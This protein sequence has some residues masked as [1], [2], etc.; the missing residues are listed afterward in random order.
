[1]DLSAVLLLPSPKHLLS[2]HGKP[3]GNIKIKKNNNNNYNT[4]EKTTTKVSKCMY[5]SKL[6]FCFLYIKYVSQHFHLDKYQFAIHFQ[7]LM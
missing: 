6:I 5:T 7:Q 2:I 4:T 3:K 1:M